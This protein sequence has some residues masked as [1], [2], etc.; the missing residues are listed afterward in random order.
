MAKDKEV[1]NKLF[2]VLPKLFQFEDEASNLMKNLNGKRRNL[3]LNQLIVSHGR[4]NQGTNAPGTAGRPAHTMPDA[5]VNTGA[6]GAVTMESNRSNTLRV[7]QNSPKKS[8]SPAK[9]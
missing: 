4:I 7:F 3:D 8:V 9:N 5:M 2:G 1:H 6:G